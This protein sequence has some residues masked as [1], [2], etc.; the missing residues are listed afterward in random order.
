MAAP[1]AR[2]DRYFYAF[3]AVMAAISVASAVGAAVAFGAPWYLAAVAFAAIAAYLASYP[4]VRTA[5]YEA[6]YLAATPLV[7]AYR[8]GEN[9]GYAVFA[10]EPIGGDPASQAVMITTRGV[11][12]RGLRNVDG[13]FTAEWIITI[14]MPPGARVDHAHIAHIPTGPATKD[15]D[16]GPPER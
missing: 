7:P 5:W 14:P 2:Y 15:P 4:W 13:A 11:T 10:S 3:A 12:C 1:G 8:P 16:P 6:G 9:G